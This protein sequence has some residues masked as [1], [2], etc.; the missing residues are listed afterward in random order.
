MI[1]WGGR[2]K[3]LK[4]ILQNDRNWQ[5]TDYAAFPFGKAVF[6][7]KK[8]GETKKTV[9]AFLK[10]DN[11]TD[12]VSLARQNDKQYS[13][14]RE[15]C[16]RCWC[17]YAGGNG[18]DDFEIKLNLYNADGSICAVHEDSSYNFPG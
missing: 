7:R 13:I 12:G 1:L 6:S 4:G 8:P 10:E 5:L 11:R 2:E 17:E 16:R 9:S 15:R 14:K 18:M 3:Q